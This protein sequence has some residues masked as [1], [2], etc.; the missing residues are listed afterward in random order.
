MVVI[1][2]V[3]CT[4]AFQHDLVMTSAIDLKTRRRTLLH[5]LS[6]IVIAVAREGRR[7]AI[8]QPDLIL[9]QARRFTP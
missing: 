5:G 8:Q 1:A 6:T 2:L 3:R 7:Q 4:R 9:Q